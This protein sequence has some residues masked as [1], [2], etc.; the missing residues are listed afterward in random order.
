MQ[1]AIGFIGQGLV[2][3]GVG[4]IMALCYGRH[5]SCKFSSADRPYRQTGKEHIYSGYGQTYPPPPPPQKLA[6]G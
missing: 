3:S 4:L 5:L 1:S 6:G 2:D